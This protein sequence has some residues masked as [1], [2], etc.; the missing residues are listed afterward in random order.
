MNY[1]CVKNEKDL[2]EIEKCQKSIDK[3]KKNAKCCIYS[4]IN[5]CCINNFTYF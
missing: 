3:S 1:S 2:E 4:N 5:S